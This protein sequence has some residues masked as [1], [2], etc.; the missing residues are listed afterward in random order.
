M[1]PSACTSVFDDPSG[2]RRPVRMSVRI[3]VAST[4]RAT[5]SPDSPRAGRSCDARAVRQRQRR[6]AGRVRSLRKSPCEFRKRDPAILPYGTG[7]ADSRRARF[8]FQLHALRFMSRDAYSQFLES[9]EVVAQGGYTRANVRYELHVV[10]NGPQLHFGNFADYRN[11]AKQEAISLIHGGSG[12]NSGHS[13][14]P[15]SCRLYLYQPCA[16]RSC[17]F[18]PRHVVGVR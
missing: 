3:Q 18:Q 16:L 11:N 12:L 15:I 7:Y 5:S 6:R 4:R 8:D 14:R 10:L 2:G 13:D 1:T 17:Q 9:F